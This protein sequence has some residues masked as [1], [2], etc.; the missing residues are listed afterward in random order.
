MDDCT[1]CPLTSKEQQDAVIEATIKAAY[2]DPQAPTSLRAIASMLPPWIRADHKRVGRRLQSM[3]STGA[4]PQLKSAFG[5]DGKFRRARKIAAAR[6]P[7]DFTPSLQL[8]CG[9][10]LHHLQEL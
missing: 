3:I 7:D 8:F 4:V 5:M 6:I 2:L 10:A 1:Q 9:D